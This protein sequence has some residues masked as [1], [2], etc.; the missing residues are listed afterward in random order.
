MKEA[1]QEFRESEFIEL[2]EC[3]CRSNVTLCDGMCMWKLLAYTEKCL[4][5]QVLFEI[6]HEC[7]LEKKK[8]V[9]KKYEEFPL[10]HNCNINKGG[11][12]GSI[13][14]LNV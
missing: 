3:R 11:S 13:P 1:S 5:Y 8:V 7:Y 2:D 12:L 4:G 14:W 9:M 10:T 6:C